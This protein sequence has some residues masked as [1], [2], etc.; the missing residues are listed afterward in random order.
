M[1]AFVERV[2]FCLPSISLVL[3]LGVA[4]SAQRVTVQPTVAT[5]GQQITV[6]VYNDT[7][8]NLFYAA[9]YSAS[10][11]CSLRIVRHSGELASRPLI[12]GQLCDALAALP[13]GQWFQQ[14]LIAPTAPGSYAVVFVSGD[15]G[16]AR[17]EVLTPTPNARQLSLYPSRIHRPQIAHQHDFS[18]PQNTPWEFANVGTT[19]HTFVSGD[20]IDL[21]TP[22]GTT[23]VATLD[24]A[25]VHVPPGKVTAVTLP[26]AGLAPG[27]YSVRAAHFDPG[28]GTAV[29]TRGGLQVM[30]SRANLHMVNGH[31]LVPGTPLRVVLTLTDFPP[32]GPTGQDPYYALMVGFQP[33]T[34]PLAGGLELGLTL[35]G[36]AVASITTQLGGLLASNVG[37]APNEYGPS[38]LF[39]EGLVEDITM[40]HPNIPALTGL[41]LRMAAVAIDASMTVWGSSQPEEFILR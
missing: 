13:P 4:A 28:A 33:G 7:A 30:G 41:P 15:R 17:L 3:A 14:P 35:D 21:F 32:P 26:S 36:L 27:P 23:L 37:Q 11:S 10:R 29:V 1:R 40:A 9:G 12:P 39:Y 19:P 24:L 5:P 6:T 22:G 18:N 20:R 8:G 2:R 34:T 25:G 38:T 31:D 16:A